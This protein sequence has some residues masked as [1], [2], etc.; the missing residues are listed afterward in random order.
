MDSTFRALWLV[1]QTR[2]ILGYSPPNEIFKMA[3]R[4]ATVTEEE[5]RQMNVEAT[6]ANFSKSELRNLSTPANHYE[7]FWSHPEI[8]SEDFRTL[9]KIFRKLKKNP[10]TSENYFWT[11]SEVFRIFPN[12]SED[13]RR[14]SEDLKNIINHLENTSEL[15]PKFSKSFIKPL[16]NGFEAFP[17]FSEI[18]RDFRTLAKISV[19]GIK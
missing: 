12:T 16:K 13:F 6:P 17:K 3:A 4:F 11:V 19:H 5:I 2:Y 7:H 18:R 15:S 8:V 9:P 1:H 10:K 14:F